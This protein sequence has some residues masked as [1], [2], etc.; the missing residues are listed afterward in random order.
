MLDL[1]T[2]VQKSFEDIKIT[3]ETWFEFWSA[4]DLM[5]NLWYKDWRKFEWVIEKARESCKNSFA[6][7]IDH[8]VRGDKMIILWK[9]WQ[10]KIEDFLLSRYACYLIAQNWDPRKK[11]ISLAQ[12]YFSSQTR[13]QE[14]AEKILEENKRL[15]AREKLKI[16]EE[17]IEKTVYQRWITKPVEFASFKNKKIETLYN[18]SVKALKARRWIPEKRALADFDSEVELKAKDFI[19]A[20]T[21]HNIKENNLIWRQK[22]EQELV[23][24][25]K[26]TR[27]TM[28]SR[29]IIPESLKAQE[30]LKKVEKRREFKEKEKTKNLHTNKTKWN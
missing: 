8:F 3:D 27:K 30:D 16:S 17:K 18:M 15:E 25:A 26:E 23:S 1:T 12:T 9:W 11:E 28:I 22:L 13:K 21:D 20:M 19:Y 29:W 10:R 5:I 2:Q 14:I 24:N 4:R 6:K 7:V